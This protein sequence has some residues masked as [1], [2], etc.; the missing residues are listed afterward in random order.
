MSSSVFKRGAA[1]G[2]GAAINISLGFIPDY[3]KVINLTDG[4]VVYE[5]TGDFAAGYAAKSQN[6]VDSGATGNS[7]QSIITA[8]GISPF[9][10]SGAAAPGFTIGSAISVAAKN[11]AYIAIRQDD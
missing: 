5:W 6:V 8:N 3:V 11:L 10:G 1:L 4:N 7:S 2:T 9:A